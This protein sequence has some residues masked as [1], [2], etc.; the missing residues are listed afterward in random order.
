MY[1]SIIG[2]PVAIRDS[3]IVHQAR[4]MKEL[5]SEAKSRRIGKRTKGLLKSLNNLKTSKEIHRIVLK[6]NRAGKFCKLPTH[7]NIH[8]GPVV[9]LY[10]DFKS[11]LRFEIDQKLVKQGKRPVWNDLEDLKP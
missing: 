4:K 2:I 3:Y 10:R 7:R 8:E 5:I 9:V 1:L 6:N 11:S